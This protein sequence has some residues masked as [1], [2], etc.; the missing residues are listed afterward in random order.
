MAPLDVTRAE[1]ELAND[2]TNLIVAQTTQ[3]QDELVLKNFI[4][5]DPMASNLINVEVIP[6]DKPTRPEAIEAASFDD[7]VKEA[8]QKR[9]DVLEQDFN[10]KNAQV[11]VRATKNALLP[12]ATLGL[13]YQSAGLPG[14][15][16]VT[17]G[18]PP[19]SWRPGADT[20]HRA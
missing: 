9:P 16:P 17:A 4:S 14:E 18:P 7:A 19:L 10:L 3:L 6:T 1:S 8:F 11:D 5:K 2:R 15:A 12:T 13:E 20:T